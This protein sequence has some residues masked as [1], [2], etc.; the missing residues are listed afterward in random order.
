MNLDRFD[1]FNIFAALMLVAAAAILGTSGG[2]TH[3][4]GAVSAKVRSE[5]ATPPD[6][7]TLYATAKQLIESGQP[8]EAVKSLA[9]IAEKF[10][11]EA[12][13]HSLLGQAYA[14]MLD[15]P[16]SMKEFRLALTIEPDYVDK[17]SGKFIGK[18]IKAVVKDGMSEAKVAL[19][20]APEDAAAKAALKD[21]YYLDRM[22]AGGC[23]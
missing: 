5:A 23:E 4:T 15:Y 6:A 14:R 10:P 7:S 20:K 18:R 12:E 19:E 8:E 11:A 1:A 22:L 17:K 9:G 21:A 3:A 13:A 16:A 2:D